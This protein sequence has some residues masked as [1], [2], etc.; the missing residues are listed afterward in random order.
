MENKGALLWLDLETTGLD[1]ETDKILEA[2]FALSNWEL[3]ILE[4]QTLPISMGHLED[5]AQP[6]PYLSQFWLDHLGA[7]KELY[8]NALTNGVSCDVVEDIILHLIEHHY[9]DAPVYLAGNSIHFDR[10]FIKEYM[11][12][13]D[14]RLHYR[15]LDVSA[16]KLVAEN[17]FGLHFEKKLVHRAESDIEESM[18]EFKFYVEKGIDKSKH[19]EYN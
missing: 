8:H 14:E 15:M 12:H 11:P 9:G 7:Y 10:A 1:P 16:L 18:A 5:P 17:K 13:L 3:N 2:S 19:K 4:Q 6:N